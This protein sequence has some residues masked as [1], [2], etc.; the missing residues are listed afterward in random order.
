MALFT[1]PHCDELVELLGEPTRIPPHCDCGGVMEP[2]AASDDADHR[3]AF[4]GA[5]TVSM[6]GG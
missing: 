5:P 4:F 1:C 2:L 3:D 6:R